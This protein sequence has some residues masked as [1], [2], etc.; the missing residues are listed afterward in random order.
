MLS[1]SIHVVPSDR[2]SFFL[3]AEN[4]PFSVCLSVCL[5]IISHLS[6]DVIVDRGGLCMC[7]RGGGQGVFGKSL[8]LGFFCEPKTAL[9]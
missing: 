9:K 4:I 3:T 6:F 1:R 2:I 7:A 5:L 8:Y